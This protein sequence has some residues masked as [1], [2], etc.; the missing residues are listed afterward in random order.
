MA[1]RVCGLCRKLHPSM[2]Q[3][4]GKVGWTAEH[5]NGVVTEEGGGTVSRRRRGVQRP[6]RVQGV[7][8]GG[9]R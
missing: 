7:V 4:P 2:A 3:P 8:P 1:Q 6:E 9:G 5:W